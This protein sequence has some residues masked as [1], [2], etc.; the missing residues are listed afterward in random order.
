MNFMK[1]KR[2][3]QDVEEKITDFF[4][5]HEKMPTCSEIA[6]IIDVH[7]KSVVHF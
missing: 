2:T 6:E 5:D 1:V 3:L 7:S 4:L